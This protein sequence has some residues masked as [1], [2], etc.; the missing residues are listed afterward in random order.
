MVDNKINIKIDDLDIETDKGNSILQ[1]AIENN[2]YIPNLCH[3]PDLKPFGACRLCVVQNEE[4]KLITAC[5]TRVEEGMAVVTESPDIN[6]VREVVIK[7]LIANHERNCLTCSSDNNCKLQE[8]ASYLGIDQDD[9]GNLRLHINDISPDESN[10]FFIRDLKK[11]ILCGVC[12]RVCDEI[13]GVNAI[14]YGFRGYDTKIIASQDKSILESNCVSCGECVVACP[15]GALV[16]KNYAKPSREIETICPYCGVGCGIYLGVRGNELISVRGNPDNPVNKGKLCVKGRYGLEFFNSPQRLTKPL[17]KKDGEFIEVKWDE[18]LDFVSLKLSEFKNHNSTNDEP[19]FALLGSAKCTNEENYIFQKFARVVMDTNNI[20]HCARSCHATT[21]AGLSQTLGSGAMTNSIDQITNTDCILAIG[22]NTTYTHPII[23]MEIIKSAK[24]GAKLI[25]ANPQEIDLCR[26]ADL[27]LQINPGSDVALLMGMMKVILDEDLVDIDFIKGRCQDYDEFK[28]SLSEFDLEFVENITGVEREKI[29]KA[30]RLYSSSGNSSIFYA[31]G[32]TQH[33]HGT[34][35]VMALSNLALLTGNLGKYSAGINPLRGQN[36]VQGS[37]DM[38]VLPDVYPGYQKIEDQNNLIKFQNA[39]NSQLSYEK[40]LTLPEIMEAS[41][42][43]EI[44]ALYIIGE[45]PIMSE[46]NSSHIKN[47]LEKLEFLIV[48]DIFLT[49]TAELA[50]VVLP[51]FSF[52]EKDGTFTNTERRVQRIHK[53]VKAP[54]DSME[55]WQIICEIARRLDSSEFNFSDSNE[56][57]QEMASLTPIYQGITYNRL[58]NKGLQWPC[59]GIKD[60]GTKFLY[61]DKFSTLNGKAKFKPLKY[62]TSAEI[63]DEKYPF[64]LT[65]KRSLYQYHT[66]TMT[67]RVEGLNNLYGHELLEIN[68]I[69][70]LNLQV[71]DGEIISVFSRRGH[72][73][74]KVKFTSSINP[75]VISMTFHF[76]ETH[77][78]LLTNT[79]TD[80]MALT[81]ELKVCAVRLEKIY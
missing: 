40:G 24:S 16:P 61:K 59:R 55:D 70:A 33:C 48:Q 26:Y 49:E 69:D 41:L 10:P 3:Y 29:K 53:A 39:W 20:D 11:C 77:T 28:D 42:N 54:G 47:S 34:D 32:I 22:T 64:I 8:V 71:E 45:N 21:V 5:E 37:C 75:G 2:I 73:K 13:L 38:G 6:S 60:Q 56:I 68:P 30:A 27:F 81:P 9:L 66:G 25:V 14:D 1:A 18:A 12:V 51:A 43:E 79:A 15:V 65:T 80:P 57:F 17:I 67:R 36:N 7:L 52:A 74:A 31:M 23:G 50:D 35:N 4:G 78:N 19:R 62:L 46:P 63:P 44:K 72:V 58:E 76:S